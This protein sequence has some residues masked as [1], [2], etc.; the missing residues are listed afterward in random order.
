MKCKAE[1]D[2]DRNVTAYEVRLS[3]LDV[4]VSLVVLTVLVVVLV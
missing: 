1:Y 2:S 3:W 4:I